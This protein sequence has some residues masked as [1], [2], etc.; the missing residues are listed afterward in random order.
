MSRGSPGDGVGWDVEHALFG[1]F[2]A[3][4]REFGPL[5][6]GG[7]TYLDLYIAA[8]M[9]ECSARPSSFQQ[10]GIGDRLYSCAVAFPRIAVGPVHASAP[11]RLGAPGAP[12]GH[13]PLTEP[14]DEQEVVQL[15]AEPVG[16]TSVDT[17]PGLGLL[18]TDPGE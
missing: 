16:E 4:F 14:V 1:G 2:A 17:R 8:N 12:R 11:P 13:L 9:R 5:L 15:P 6:T 18:M 3:G 10:Q 7:R